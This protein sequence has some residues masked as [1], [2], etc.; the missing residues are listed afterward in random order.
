VRASGGLLTVWDSTKVEV[1]RSSV[2]REHVLWSHGRFV[3]SGEELFLA[4]LYVSCD[5]G[6]TVGLLN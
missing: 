3:K 6:A 1:V 4:N 5:S 2:S